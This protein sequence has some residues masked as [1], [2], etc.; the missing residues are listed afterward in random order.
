[1]EV[2]KKFGLKPIFG[3]NPL[4]GSYVVRG[5]TVKKENHFLIESESITGG[6][7][8]PSRPEKGGRGRKK[9]QR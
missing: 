5:Y 7:F 1:L 3:G 6:R 8:V 2:C 9:G 4:I